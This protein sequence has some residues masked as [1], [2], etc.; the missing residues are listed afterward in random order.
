MGADSIEE[1]EWVHGIVLNSAPEGISEGF[2]LK[3]WIPNLP[4]LVDLSV[5][6]TSISNGEVWDVTMGLEGW[7]PFNPEFVIASKGVNGQD[8]FL[9]IDGL[10]VGD[11]TSLLVESVFR[12][13]TLGGITE[14]STSTLYSMSNRLEWFHAL[15]LDRQSGTR[16]EMMVQDIPESVEIQA[17]LGNAISMDVTVP[18]EFRK[19]DLGV[20]SI[21]IQQLQWME[22]S[23]WPATMFLT[24][25]PGSMNLTTEPDLNFD[26]TKNLAFQGMPILDFSASSEG[27]SLY[28]E[29]KGRAINSRGDIVLMAEGLADRLSIKPTESFGLNI[30]SSGD[31]VDRLYFRANDIPTLPPVILEQMEAMGE[32]LKSAKIEI[33]EFGRVTVM[34][35]G[36]QLIEVSDVQGGR[37][38]ISA[39]ATAEVN[40]ID[41]DLRGVMLDAQVTGG[42]PSGT[43]LGVNGFASDLSL[44]N[45]IPG[46]SGS[47]SHWM[48]PEPVSSGILTAVATLGGM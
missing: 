20:G 24:E 4:A 40:G 19:G 10:Q 3:M 9:T 5:S 1:P 25:I 15:L 28:I 44:L 35:P 29:A 12:T 17:S 16:T 41:V 21:M 26:I 2:Y 6:R 18:E 14:T 34:I 48:A 22:S 38:I 11:P 33:H 7:E 8:V 37:I 31:G 47:T 27:M 39:R 45:M 42:I 13:E 30:R 43:T 23:W 46:F 36:Y 32:N